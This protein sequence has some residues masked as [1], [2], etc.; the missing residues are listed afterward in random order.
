MDG[1]YQNITGDLR[2]SIGYVIA[3]NG[4]IIKEGG[5][6][7]IQGRGNNMQ[8]V[9]FTTKDG[10][11]VSFWAKGKFG[12][13]SHGSKEGLEFAMGNI[14]K[15]KEL[16][17]REFISDIYKI[18]SNVLK[19]ENEEYVKRFN[20]IEQEYRAKFDNISSFID[21]EKFSTYDKAQK[22]FC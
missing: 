22:I 7:K 5:F 8:K 6:Y 12:D 4:K 18:Y 13:G 20:V 21:F 2:S 16:A 10:K 3:Y 14:E 1:N 9:E 17:T 15:A 19:S 11:Q